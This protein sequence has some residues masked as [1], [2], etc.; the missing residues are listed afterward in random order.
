MK[1]SIVTVIVKCMRSHKLQHN[2]NA[3]DLFV[4]LCTSMPEDD[5]IDRNMQRC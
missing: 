3:F 1:L 2:F 5:L 4:K